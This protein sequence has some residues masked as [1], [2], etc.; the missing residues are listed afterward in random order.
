MIPT[1]LLR[2]G[3]TEMPRGTVSPK[4]LRDA[5]TIAGKV[6]GVFEEEGLGG[7]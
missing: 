7:N 3:G 1:I 5:G 4:L 6:Y 2:A